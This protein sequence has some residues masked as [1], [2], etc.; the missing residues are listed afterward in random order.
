MG[1]GA[2]FSERALQYRRA[3]AAKLRRAASN[4]TPLPPHSA[5]SSVRTQPAGRKDADKRSCALDGDILHAV[6]LGFRVARRDGE[7]VVAGEVGGGEQGA[8][9]EVPVAAAARAVASACPAC[10]LPE[11]SLM[12][13]TRPGLR[14]YA[15]PR[16]SAT[17]RVCGRCSALSVTPI[18]RTTRA[19]RHFWRRRA[20]VAARVDERALLRDKVGLRVGVLAAHESPLARSS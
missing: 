5:V 6:R 12:R 4:A 13:R 20:T 7:Q 2:R 15:S 9:A 10:S 18:W 11:R 1:S 8:A 14:R 16:A 3:I 17:R 19:A